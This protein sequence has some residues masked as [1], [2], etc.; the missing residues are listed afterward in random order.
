M[1][2]QLGRMLD[3]IRDSKRPTLVIFLGDNGPLPTFMQSRTVGLRGSKLSLY[4]GGIRVPLIAWGPGL[5]KAGVKNTE[6][7]ISA[8][9]FFPSLCKL[10][11]APLPKGYEPDGENLS[12]VLLGA[13]TPKRKKPI[14]WEYGRNDTSFAYPKDGGNRSPNLSV[15]DGNWKLLVNAEGGKTELYDLA[16][17][18][19]ETNNLAP[20]NPEV[21]K[22]MTELVLKW[23][24]SLP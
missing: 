4:E 23:R 9:D 21:T 15:R 11:G 5:V 2:K 14:Y 20:A 24:K 3:A 12:A 8:L 10:C 7:V 16:A 22:R 19:K 18:P 13:A 6:T 17:D 1:D